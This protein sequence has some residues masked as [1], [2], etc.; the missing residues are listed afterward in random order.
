MGQAPTRNKRIDVSYMRKRRLVSGFSY[1]ELVFSVAILALLATAATPYLEQTVTRKKE[2]EL[3]RDL[4]EIRSAI[5]AYKKAYDEGHM[6]KIQGAS[7]YPANLSDLVNGVP[8][9]Q[10]PQKRKMRFL[11]KIPADPMFDGSAKSAE[12]TWG[13]RA[14]DSDIDHP[15]EGADVYDVYSMSVQKGLNGIPYQEW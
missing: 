11:R 9:V 5:D 8:D 4:R 2:E 12:E 7:G 1:I 3:R 13:K 15:R 6:L 10:D 14:Y